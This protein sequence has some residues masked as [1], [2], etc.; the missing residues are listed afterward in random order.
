LLTENLLVLVVV[1]LYQEGGA[2]ALDKVLRLPAEYTWMLDRLVT[3]TAD[4]EMA[5]DSDAEAILRLI[6]GLRAEQHPERWGQFLQAASA[7]WLELMERAMPNI[8]RAIEAIVTVSAAD[9]QQRGLS[10]KELGAELESQRLE[11]VRRSLSC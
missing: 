5:A 11:A 1:V 2:K 3:H 10:G 9:L 6:N 7:I 4:V 8:N